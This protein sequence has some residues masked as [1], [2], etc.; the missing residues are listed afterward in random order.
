MS[1]AAETAVTVET[2][3]ELGLLPEEFDK[4]VDYLGRV[5]NYTELS[6]SS[7]M[8]SEHCSYKNSKL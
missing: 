7:V 8:W 1:I 6:I 4:I 3:R 5:P 2:A